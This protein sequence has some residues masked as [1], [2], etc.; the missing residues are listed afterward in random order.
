MRAIEKRRDAGRLVGIR[1][2]AGHS[3]LGGAGIIPSILPTCSGA[4]ME[5]SSACSLAAG[6]VG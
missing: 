5:L 6:G 2:A 1:V 4:A 3:G